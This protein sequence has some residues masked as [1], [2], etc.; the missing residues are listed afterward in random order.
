MS[1]LPARRCQNYSSGPAAQLPRVFPSTGFKKIDPT[2]LVEEENL[3]SYR[4]ED[5]YPI[6]IGQV[7]ERNYQVVAKLG[8]GTT[9]TVWLSRDLRD[10]KFRVLKVHVNTLKRNQELAVYQHLSGLCLDHPGRQ[11]V[12]QFRD[13]FKLAGLHGEH[14]VFVMPP[15]GMSLRTLQDMQ[16]DKVFQQILVKSALDQILFGLNYLHDADVIHTGKYPN[17]IM[18]PSWRQ[19]RI[20]S[21]TDRQHESDLTICDLGQARIGKVHCSKA[22][23][24]PS[25][26]P[27]V[28]LGMTWGNSVDVWS[29]GLLAWDLLQQEGI[30]RVY[31][32][33]EELNDARLVASSE[34]NYW[35]KDGEW[36][37]TVPLPPRRGIKAIETNL[38]GEDKDKFLDFL[39]GVL[40]WLPEDRLNSF[41][42]YFHPWLRGEGAIE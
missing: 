21:F 36:H 23:P 19:W 42:A 15:L 18:T 8:Y 1:Q 24:T 25:R 5:Y 13:A 11:H 16:K 40:T 32:Q 9:S 31:D 37:G 22:I 41:E 29:V 6:R 20:M 28:I 4:R 35:N 39:A 12:R 14:D 17:L 26:A 3:P 10:K 27:E 30:F 2:L 38:S 7:I 33:S 34:E